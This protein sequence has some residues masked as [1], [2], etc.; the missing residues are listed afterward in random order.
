MYMDDFYVAENIIGY[1]GSILNNPT[2]YFRNGNTFGRITQHHDDPN[3]V[4][5]NLVRTHAD[6]F[7]ENEDGMAWEYY[8]GDWQH[9]SRSEFES[10]KAVFLPILRTCITRFPNIKPGYRDLV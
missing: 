7:I 1:T 4:G 6:Y 8:D 5:R 10:I 9:N 3:N 2:M